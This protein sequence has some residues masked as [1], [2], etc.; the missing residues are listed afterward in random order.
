MAYDDDEGAGEPYDGSSLATRHGN[1][2][3]RKIQKNK[4]KLEN[5]DFN[6]IQFTYIF[7]IPSLILDVF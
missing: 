1:G 2:M 7:L 4:N 3:K 6:V 5:I